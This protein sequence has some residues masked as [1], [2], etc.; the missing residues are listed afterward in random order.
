MRAMGV[1]D[2]RI[3]LGH[4]V[5]DSVVVGLELF[6][7]MPSVNGFGCLNVC[8]RISL[9][10][11]VELLANMLGSIMSVRLCGRLALSVVHQ[12]ALKHGYTNV[13]GVVVQ[14]GLRMLVAL[15]VYRVGCHVH[16]SERL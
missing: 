12:R 3:R 6:V 13:L 11:Y 15:G 9:A 14:N 2:A 4:W 7:T 8:L 1:L 16:R 5:Y 10:R